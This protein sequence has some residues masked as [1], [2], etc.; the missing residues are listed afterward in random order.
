VVIGVSSLFVASVLGLI[1]AKQFWDTYW[2][3]KV[4]FTF[5]IIAVYMITLFP[6]SIGWG[7]KK[8]AFLS[9]AGFVLLMFSYTIV[10][11]FIT[12]EHLFW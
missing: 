9:I 11:L 4:L 5:L 12:Q 7:G 3:P 1:R 8:V 2:D 6:R 10:N